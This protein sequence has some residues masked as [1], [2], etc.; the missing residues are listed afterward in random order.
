MAQAFAAY[1]A[2]PA[3]LNKPGRIWG[4]AER[5][6]KGVCWMALEDH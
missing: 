2:T 5:L 4:D 1:V 3:D 6:G